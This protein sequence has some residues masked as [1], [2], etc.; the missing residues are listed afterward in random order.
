MINR[1][2][3]SVFSLFVSQIQNECVYLQCQT[4][5]IWRQRTYW[6][7][8][9]I[10]RVFLVVSS[11]WDGGRLATKTREARLFLYTNLKLSDHAKRPWK[12]PQDAKRPACR[13]AYDTGALYLQVSKRKRPFAR[14]VRPRFCEE[15]LQSQ[16]LCVSLQCQNDAIASQK[17][18]FKRDKALSLV[19]FCSCSSVVLANK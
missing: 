15:N 1:G 9:A 6:S 13:S 16:K 17:Y 11:L 12:R 14:D 3:A 2:F 8:S 18:I 5:V 7:S 10:K 4:F 19:H